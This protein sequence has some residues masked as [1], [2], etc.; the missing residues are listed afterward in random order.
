MKSPITSSKQ[1]K[2]I[3]QVVRIMAASGLLIT[4][5][6][7][8]SVIKAQSSNKENE[9]KKEVQ[10]TVA[11]LKAI[12][13]YYQN[14]DNKDMYVQFIPSDNGLN[15]K[16]LWNGA[17]LHLSPESELEFSSKQGERVSIKFIKA[18]DGSISQFTLNNDTKQVWA[19]SKDYKS[20]VKKEIQLSPEKLKMFEGL[21]TNHGGNDRFLQ[22]TVKENGLILKQHWD[23]QEVPM[24][25]EAETDFYSKAQHLFT[26]HFNMDASGKVTDMIAFKRDKWDKIEPVVPSSAQLKLLE[27]RYQFKDDN[28]NIIEIKAKGA[29]LVVRQL[30][31]KKEIEVACKTDMYFYNSEQSFAVRFAKD[32]EGNITQVFILGDDLFEKIK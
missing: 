29:N 24:T 5:L 12:E 13:G 7:Y 11:Q 32:K 14:Q 10:V 30:W 28:D 22:F 25:P 20:I 26:I 19:R 18:A 27:G 17:Q 9:P 3:N 31:D 16:L 21:Y 6:F 2:V 15:A 8:T 4:C 23:S 1:H